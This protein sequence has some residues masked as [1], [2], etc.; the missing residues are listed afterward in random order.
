MYGAV[1]VGGND[2]DGGEGGEGQAQALLIPDLPIRLRE[3]SIQFWPFPPTVPAIIVEST[4][5]ISRPPPSSL[6]VPNQTAMR[7]DTAGD[8]RRL[9]SYDRCPVA[10]RRTV[11]GK[12]PGYSLVLPM[13]NV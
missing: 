10:G 9:T 2:E 6:H 5:N 8:G 12:A 7:H 11:D 3:A 4:F 1:L 13:V